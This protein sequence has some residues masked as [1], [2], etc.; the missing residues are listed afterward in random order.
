MATQVI[1][2]VVV[3]KGSAQAGQRIGD[4]GKKA[5]QA[6]AGL[7]LFKRTLGLIGGAVIIRGLIGISDA[8]IGLRNRLR[9]VTAT[10]AQTNVVLEELFAISNRSRADFEATAETFARLAA[11]ARTLGFN[12][13]D[14]L[15]VTE[16]LNQAIVLS[17]ATAREAQTALIQLSQAFARGVLRG[18]E[19]RSVLEQLPAV[20]DV[21]AKQM[22]VTRFELARLGE[23]GKITAT[24]IVEAF[25]AAREEL[26]EKFGRTVPTIGQAFTVFRNRLVE[27]VGAINDATGASEGLANGIIT[28]GA[29]LDIL[30][31]AVAALAIVITVSLVQNAFG[32]LLRAM[33]ALNVAFLANPFAVAAS[34]AVVFAAVLIS[35]SDKIFVTSDGLT[36]LQDVG[37]VVFGHLTDAVKFTFESFRLF[38]NLVGRAADFVFGPY[39]RA[40]KSITGTT[41][42]FI[43]L[44]ARIPILGRAI[45]AGRAVLESAKTRAELREQRKALRAI[46]DEEARRQLTQADPA[47]VRVTAQEER[48]AE[49][50]RRLEA[51][52]KA[53]LLVGSARE[54]ENAFIKVSNKFKGE[55]T[56]PQEILLRQTIKQNQQ[57]AVEG[58]LLEE[59]IGKTVEFTDTMRALNAV[60]KRGD[61]TIDQFNKKL[62]ELEL[63]KLEDRTDFGAGIDR[64]LID[65]REKF[66]DV[67]TQAENAFTNA[68]QGMEDALTE[69]IATGKLSFSDLV[70]SITADISRIAVQQALLKPLTNFLFPAGEGGAGGFLSGLFGSGSSSAGGENLPVA[71]HGADFTVRGSGGTDSQVVAFRATPGERVMVQTPSG[72]GGGGPAINITMNI[73]TPDAESFGRSQGQL[74]SRAMVSA[75]RARQRNT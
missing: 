20:A 10:V 50:I 58:A 11:S 15:S 42:S 68:F 3:E 49:E 36:T 72:E 12:Q 44:L 34:A 60:F 48:F 54:R 39:I 8:F 6:N 29:N 35:V 18:D 31:R 7:T 53:L 66:N 17:G 63:G 64:A 33:I 23:Q 56:G 73:N 14:L 45:G 16:S 65:L 27:T 22:G 74:I 19:L 75:E 1:Q 13:K 41:G 47:A 61:I 38:F 52:G 70:D 46:E 24:I 57:L 9:T 4:V 2:I 69:F 37:V 71:K 25:I 21:I 51:T 32:A 30:V 43:D 5:A 59:I 67:A 26:G 40:L 28:M 62:R 55:L